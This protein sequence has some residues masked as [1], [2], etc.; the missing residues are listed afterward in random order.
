MRIAN[1][2]YF[3]T[4]NGEGIRT[5]VFVSGCSLHCPGCFNSEVWSF[6]Y[7]KKYDNELEHKILESIDNEYCS[8]LSILGGEPLDKMNQE[9]VYNL[10]VS[11]KSRFG[12]KKNVWLWTGYT[13]DNIPQTVFTDEILKLVDYIVD[14][15]FKKDLADVD[16]AYRGSS[17]Q[18]ILENYFGKF[19]ETDFK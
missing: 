1:I 10:L 5:A 11:F 12:N 19:I 13:L 8:G 18:R 16:L 14:G 9:G 7:G 6:E 4:V 3:S 17:N 2:K 15:P